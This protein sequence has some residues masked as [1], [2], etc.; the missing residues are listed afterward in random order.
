MDINKDGREDIILGGNQY[1]AQPQTGIYAGSFGSVMINNGKRSF[2]PA[3]GENSG[4]A[5]EGQ[6]RD[7]QKLRFKGEELLLIAR[8]DDSLAIFKMNQR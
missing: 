1:K 5:V 4:F 6:I 3:S 8:N 2:Q 7:I